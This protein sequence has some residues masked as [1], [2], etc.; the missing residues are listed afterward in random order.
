MLS[1]YD[2]RTA[3]RL[4]ELCEVVNERYDGQQAVVVPECA[5]TPARRCPRSAEPGC[6]AGRAG[7]AVPSPR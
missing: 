3:T 1:P 4:L 2:F 5:G 7:S 6:G